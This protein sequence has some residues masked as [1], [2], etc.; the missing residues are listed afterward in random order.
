MKVLIIEDDPIQRHFYS[1]QLTEQGH[2]VDG[3]DGMAGRDIGSDGLLLGLDESNGID[4]AI[5]DQ[6]LK[7]SKFSGTDII[8]KW[9][10]EGRYFPIMLLTAA[11]REYRIEAL[12][13][14]ADAFVEK[15]LKP[16]EL[17]AEFHALLRREDSGQ[18]KPGFR[19]VL[20][21]FELDLIERT[22]TRH[23]EPVKLEP[24][25]YKLAELLMT[26]AG[27]VVETTHLEELVEKWSPKEELV[28]PHNSARVLVRK[29]RKRLDPDENIDPI[30]TL[31][32]TGY[33]FRKPKKTGS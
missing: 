6:I 1:T 27:R 20:P 23:G 12:E 3:P 18:R 11:G 15:P 7:E 31:R 33:R 10:E 14:G 13:S 21:P 30:E 28:N 24:M 26:R 32:G 16:R 2:V 22:V 17:L 9:R 4:I 19:K 5:V 25:E 29:L 8:Q